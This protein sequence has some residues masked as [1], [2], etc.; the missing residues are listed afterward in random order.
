LDKLPIDIDITAILI[1][2]SLGIVSFIV[3][4]LFFRQRQR[5]SDKQ[6]AFRDALNRRVI[7]DRGDGKCYS[8]EWVMDN[9]TQ[10]PRKLLS[11]T[12]LLIATL[13]LLF[14]VF[15][16]GIMPY[17]V[18]NVI[19]LGYTTVIALIGI[20]ILLWTDAFEAYSY[21]NAVHKVTTEKLDK[22]DQS[23]IELARE[24][25]EKA[26]LRFVSMGVA[27]A[28]LGPFIPQIFNGFVNV[29]MLYTTAFFQGSE[30]SFKAFTFFGAFIVL[31]LIAFMLF[32]LPVVLGGII[33]R[34]AKS[35]IDKMFKRRAEQ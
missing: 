24:A 25:L 1:M 4:L 23:Y 15:L 6:R 22:E 28:V 13:S 34:K 10:K 16:Y 18:S 2:E 35:L 14:A 31:I 26:F 19:S 29:F 17:I 27:F 12:P 30:A 32:F 20:A 21:T 33:I 8:S 7:S 11:A 5:I 3:A 9:I